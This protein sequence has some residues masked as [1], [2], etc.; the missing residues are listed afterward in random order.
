MKASV[1]N[2]PVGWAIRSADCHMRP[3]IVIALKN[4]YSEPTKHIREVKLSAPGEGCSTHDNFVHFPS[5]MCLSLLQG[6]GCGGASWASRKRE[7]QLS[8]QSDVDKEALT[9]FVILNKYDFSYILERQDYSGAL[10]N[11]A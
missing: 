2:L 1:G 5:I 11:T 10:Q 3:R 9:L 6:Q 7:S 8:I 4:F